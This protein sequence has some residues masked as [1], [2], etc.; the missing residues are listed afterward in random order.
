MD[1]E[2]RESIFKTAKKWVYEAGQTIREEI[3]QPI[4]VT[5]KSNANDLVTNIDQNT[6][7]FFA[8]RIRGAYPEHLIFGEEGYGDDIASL[9][10]I[11]WIIDPI[12]G[13]MN[14]VHQK[15]SFAISIGV[16]VDG[17]GEIG[18]TYDVMAD[19]L[20]EAKRGEG[21]FKNG[22]RLPKLTETLDLRDSII[23]L[24]HFW[25]CENSRVDEKVMQSFV[26]TI[27]G[28]RTTGAATLEM[29]YVAEGVL[30]GYLAL[31]LSPWDISAGIVLINEV[32]GIVTNHLGAEVNMLETNSLVAA[33]ER[34]HAEIIE[35]FMRKGSK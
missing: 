23:G 25:L 12:D 1:K 20:Y 11:V 29:A 35:D 26:R 30:D 19:V 8:D 16:Y 14:F 34:I 33:N 6:E 5:T 18:L 13:T 31:R 9:E 10:G 27:R 32:G 4:T 28:A 7:K 21:A 15:R 22:V 24:N 17:I 3:N 2:L